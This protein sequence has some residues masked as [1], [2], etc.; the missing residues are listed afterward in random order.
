MKKLSAIAILVIA[1]TFSAFAQSASL[2]AIFDK[3]SGK[4]GLVSVSLNN[5]LKMMGDTGD[6]E[7]MEA[8]KDIKSLKVLTL[9]GD[10]KAD[11]NLVK[12]FA[13]DVASLNATQDGYEE[14]MSV[15]AGGSNVKMYLKKSGEEVLEFLMTVIQKEE[16]IVLI[17][18]NG[19]IDPTKM[20]Q[21]GNAMGGFKNAIKGGKKGGSPTKG[22]KDTP[23]ID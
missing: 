17:W 3:Y 23:K 13:K 1:M 22:K 2:K 15:N 8:L 10:S 5:P 11:P 7:A 14:F 18:A 4:D 21:I 6:D 20:S 19:K 12:E 9:D 16:Q